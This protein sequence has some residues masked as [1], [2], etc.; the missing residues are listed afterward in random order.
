MRHLFARLDRQWQLVA[1]LQEAETGNRVKV[2]IGA[3]TP[4]FSLSGSP[5][6]ISPYQDELRSLVGV[7][8]VIAPTRSDYVRLVPMVDHTAQLVSTL[9]SRQNEA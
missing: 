7:V 6:I 4:L 8:G 1:L 2:F 9:L 5:L 3:Q